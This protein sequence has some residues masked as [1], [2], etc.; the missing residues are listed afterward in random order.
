MQNLNWLKYLRTKIGKYGAITLNNIEG[1]NYT[2]TGEAMIQNL[3]Q[4]NNALYGTSQPAANYWFLGFG[5]GTSENALN[6]WN[7][8]SHVEDKLTLGSVSFVN[9]NEDSSLVGSISCTVT[10]SSADAVEIA[11]IGIFTG[12]TNAFDA[13]KIFMLY[14]ETFEAVTLQP[15]ETRSFTINFM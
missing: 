10:N 12:N 13:T 5:S 15:N 9:P 1:N 4:I 11:E 14:R 6:K 3:S 7:L 8:D 2:G